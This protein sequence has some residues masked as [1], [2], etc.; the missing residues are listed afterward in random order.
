MAMLKFSASISE[1]K[2]NS[3]ADSNARVWSR[4]TH[5][6]T[7][8]RPFTSYNYALK[9]TCFS[10][11]TTVAI[12]SA[13]SKSSP[14][15]HHIIWSTQTVLLHHRSYLSRS[16]SEHCLVSEFHSWHNS[17]FT[18]NECEGF[19]RFANV[20]NIWNH[21]A[22]GQVV[23]LFLSMKPEAQVFE[24]TSPTKKI[25]LNYILLINQE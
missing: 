10:L 4:G 15:W 23:L 2:S 18:K 16:E 22:A 13:H 25:S 19:I 11:S 9:F 7:R 3:N 8:S 6:P 14:W 1:C 24:I 12:C 17:F 20:R 5:F 21:V